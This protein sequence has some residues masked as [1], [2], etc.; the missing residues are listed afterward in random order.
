MPYRLALPGSTLLSF[1]AVRILTRAIPRPI[2]LQ[3]GFDSICLSWNSNSC[4]SIFFLALNPEIIAV[5]VS[6]AVQPFFFRAWEFLLGYQWVKKATL[7]ELVEDQQDLRSIELE[8]SLAIDQ[9]VRRSK[10]TKQ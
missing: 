6:L 5:G 10:I 7:D 9:I 2:S 8:G 4:D 3:I 1:F